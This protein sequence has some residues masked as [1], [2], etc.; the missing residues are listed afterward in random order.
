MTRLLYK[1]GLAPLLAA[2]LCAAASHSVAA[3]PIYSAL[4]LG[5]FGGPNSEGPLSGGLNA[6]GQ[7]VGQADNGSGSFDAFLTAPNVAITPSDNLGTLPGGTSSVGYGLNNTGEAV[8]FADATGT[9]SHAFVYDG[10]LPLHDLGTFG[11]TKS[12]AFGINDSG[13]SVGGADNASGYSNAFVHSGTGAL[14][15]SDNIGTFGGNQSTAQAINNSG[16]VTGEAQ[17]AGGNFHAFLH[18]GDRG[19]GLRR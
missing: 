3:A 16:Q 12:V 1:A 11:G 15:P 7:S 17:T 8:G 6:F 4:D 14:S 18:S 13:T 2:A 5:T 9:T 10:T 19:A